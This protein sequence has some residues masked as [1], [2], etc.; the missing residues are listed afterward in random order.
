MK[1]WKKLLSALMLCMGMAFGGLP[2]MMSAA[3]AEELGTGVLYIGGQDIVAAA[4]H[5][6]SDGS[7]GTATLSYNESGAPVLTLENYTYSGPG[8]KDGDNNSAAIFFNNPGSLNTLFLQLIGTSSLTCT[9]I[10]SYLSSGI[11]IRRAS[12][13][14]SG[15]GELSAKGGDTTSEYGTSNGINVSGDLQIL[16]GTVIGTGGKNTGRNHNNGIYANNISISGGTVS[17]TGGETTRGNA[18][19]RGICANSIEITG[20]EVTAVG[21]TVQGNKSYSIGISVNGDI[22]IKGGTVKAEGGTASGSDSFSYGIELGGTLSIETGITSVEAEGKSQAI[23]GTVKNAMVGTGWTVASSPF[24]SK[25][26]DISSS[27]ASIIYPKVQFPGISYPLDYAPNGG[28]G[29]MESITVYDGEVY[30]FPDC[31]FEAPDGKIFKGWDIS[32]VDSFFKFA[33]GAIQTI[34]S[35][36]VTWDDNI[37][38][39]ANWKAADRAEVTEDP[40][41]NELTYSGTDQTL[42]TAGTAVNGTMQYVLGEDNTT[43]PT[44]GWSGDI[45]QGSASGKYYVWYRAKGDETHSNSIPQCITVEIQ[46]STQTLTVTQESA[47]IGEELPSPQY[48]EPEG[49]LKEPTV[50]YS[51]TL[52]NGTVYGPSETPPTEGGSYTVTVTCETQDSVYTGTADFSIG[53]KSLADITI[54]LIPGDTFPYDG[55]EHEITGVE[56]RDGEKLLTEGVDY[57]IMA[58]SVLKAVKVGNYPITVT[59]DDKAASHGITLDL[60]GMAVTGSNYKGTVTVFWHITPQSD[61]NF[62]RLCE[63]C[64][65]PATGFSGL[66]PT[67]LGEQP[68][69]LRYEPIR[70]RLMIPSLY[71]DSE[72]VRVPRNGDSWPVDWLGADAGVLAGSA[73]PGEGLSVI[74]AHNTLNTTSYGPFALLSSLDMN[75]LIAVSSEDNNNLMFFRVY[76]NELLLPDEMEKL[77]A[78]AGQEED[79]LVLVA[80][81]NESID[82]GYLNRRVVFAKPV[83]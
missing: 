13:T 31:G 33:P 62:F 46:K 82:G 10:Q 22:T 75:D 48:E 57:E 23:N 35:N 68:K 34:V 21:S 1:N 73:L 58:D 60:E 2:G 65:L 81:E 5:T 76:A 9:E 67:V 54:T 19:S 45:P 44:S 27:G 8:H 63:D 79:A 25:K 69:E 7:G 17:A 18:W 80:C 71:V 70:M 30:E 61:Q 51:G 78:I 64:I 50:S 59:A 36:M 3:K 15:S 29:E 41:E 42:T 20:G 49:M 83:L 32:G 38:V 12:L 72:L 39:T 28:S 24:S 11:Y 47:F 26:I 40:E 6:V 77:A 14:I 43:V 52:E 66:R 55:N 74:A 37:V 53:M 56:V 16:S 4:D